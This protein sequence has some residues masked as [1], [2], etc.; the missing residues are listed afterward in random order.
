MC[1]LFIYFYRKLAKK[2]KIELEKEKL[3]KDLMREEK[4]DL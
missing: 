2:K 4:G 1:V 3:E